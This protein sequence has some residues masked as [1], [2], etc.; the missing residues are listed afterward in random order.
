[1]RFAVVLAA[2]VVGCLCAAVAVAAGPSAQTQAATDITEASASLH[3]LVNPDDKPTTYWFELGTTTAYGTTTAPTSMAKGK[4]AVRV[5]GAVSGLRPGAVYHAR[6]VAKIDKNTLTGADMTFTTAAAPVDPALSPPSGTDPITTLPAQQAVLPSLPQPGTPELGHS[7]TVTADSGQILVRVP[8]AAAPTALNGGALVPV[9]SIVDARH[10]TVALTTALSG[11]ATQTGTFHGGVF[12][13]RQPIGAHGLTELVLRGNL[14]SC[15]VAG[16]AHAAAATAKR[17]PRVLW[18][19]DNHGRFRTR[20][21]NAVIT[22]RGTTWFMADRCDGT[23]TRV[24]QGSVSVR[25]LHRDRTVV[26]T[27]GHRY[28]AKAP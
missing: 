10:G 22:V 1:V 3:G 27:A 9:G 8:G 20:G 25:D 18:G 19:H 6:V 11:G 26:V 21:S 4:V 5:T 15:P 23:L 7:A 28:L 24:A 17:P 16:A 12:Q 14:P 2:L 13:V